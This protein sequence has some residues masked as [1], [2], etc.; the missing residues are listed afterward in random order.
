MQVGEE[1]RRY[2]VEIENERIEPLAR[3]RLEEKHGSIQQDERI[4]Y[5]WRCLGWIRVAERNHK[6]S[7]QRSKLKIQKEA[8]KQDRSNTIPLTVSES[9]DGLCTETIFTF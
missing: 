8:D 2:Q 3:R 4:V 9:I 5:K 6:R 7:S 1:L